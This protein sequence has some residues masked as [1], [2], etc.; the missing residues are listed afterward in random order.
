MADDDAIIERLSRFTP[1]ASGLD[2]DALL[3]A[4]GRASSHTNSRWRVLACVLLMTQVG[5]FGALWRLRMIPVSELT[6]HA[7]PPPTAIESAP[8]PVPAPPVAEPARLA[9][10]RRLLLTADGQLP[11]SA[12]NRALIP[13]APPLRAF[14]TP[15]PDL[16]N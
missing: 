10:L 1:D 8:P 6:T 5:T 2:R 16:L 3:F 14:G 13:S 15:P 4:A 9:H 7:L 11:R 12:A